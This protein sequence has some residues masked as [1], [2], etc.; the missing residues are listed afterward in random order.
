VAKRLCVAARK[1][2]LGDAD[3]SADELEG[4]L[5]NLERV[6]GYGRRQAI[7]KRLRSSFLGGK[8][9]GALLRS[10]PDARLWRSVLNSSSVGVADV[11]CYLGHG[12]GSP[13][14]R[15]EEVRRRQGR[16]G[17]QRR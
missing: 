15:A 8:T 9:V 12:R 11:S 14:A 5:A 17:G 3:S 16:S 2:L 6:A 4:V 7:A 10:R 13:A 1:M